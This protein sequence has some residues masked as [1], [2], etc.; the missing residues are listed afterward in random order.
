MSV[1]VKIDNEIIRPGVGIIPDYNRLFVELFR[2]YFYNLGV[3]IDAEYK[4]QETSRKNGGLV[5]I[6]EHCF[7]DNNNVV[8]VVNKSILEDPPNYYLFDYIVPAFINLA[9]R[10][11]IIPSL[12]NLCLCIGVILPTLESIIYKA[13]SNVYDYNNGVITDDF[14]N[15]KSKNPTPINFKILKYLKQ[16]ASDSIEGMLLDSKSPVGVVAVANN[17]RNYNL[18]WNRGGVNQA[19][20]QAQLTDSQTAAAGF[21]GFIGGG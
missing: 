15:I 19:G 17:S 16:L 5:Y 3:D 14:Y 11:N 6:S 18:Q 12:N 1:N 9:Y 20:H 4:D 21:A 2:K 7:V 8:G 10:Y 13:E